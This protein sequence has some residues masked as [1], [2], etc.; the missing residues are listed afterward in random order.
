MT[1]PKKTPARK[2]PPIYEKI[3]PA[4]LIILAVV[5]VGILVAAFGVAL[6][7]IA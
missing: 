7:L 4:V 3:V 2:Y 6:G 5:I 1:P